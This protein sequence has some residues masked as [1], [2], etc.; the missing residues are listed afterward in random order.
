MARLLL[1]FCLGAA[2]TFPAHAEDLH[3]HE[4]GS[5]AVLS[6]SAFAHG[7]RHGYEEGYHL[8]NTDINMGAGHRTKLKNIRGLKLGYSSQ[9]G[10]RSAFQKGFHAGVRVGYHDGYSGHTFRA[11]G[12]LRSLA[13]SLEEAHSPAEPK[14]AYFDQGFFSGYNDGLE[15]GGSGQPSTAQVDFHAVGCSNFQPVK[16][17]DPFAKKSYCEGYQRGFALGLGDRMVLGPDASRLEA[18]K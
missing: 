3:L 5:A 15:H 11:I 4:T 8:G 10:S 9:F 2:L 12:T 13:G 18:S 1:A 14:F 7:Y 17:S 16:Q 6:R